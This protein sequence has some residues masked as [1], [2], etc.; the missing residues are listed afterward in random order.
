MGLQLRL[1]LIWRVVSLSTQE[2]G[3]APHSVHSRQEELE[4]FGWQ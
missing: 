3:T 1:A 4:S 2:K